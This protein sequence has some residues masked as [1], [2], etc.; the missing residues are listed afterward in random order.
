MISLESATS[1]LVAQGAILTVWNSPASHY[2]VGELRWIDAHRLFW[3]TAHGDRPEDGH[4]LE[5]DR[6]DACDP[7]TIHFFLRRKRVA[8]LSNIPQAQV[9][10]PEDYT[11]AFALWQQVA[12]CTRALIDRAHDALQPA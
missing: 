1:R 12:P 6:A 4:V 7:A 5:F 2:L 10:D 11:V 9:D 8:L 3:F